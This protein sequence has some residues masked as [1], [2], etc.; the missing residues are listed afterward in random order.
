MK[1]HNNECKNVGDLRHRDGDPDLVGGDEVKEVVKKKL[2]PDM[3][4]KE[5]L[6]RVETLRRVISK[7]SILFSDEDRILITDALAVHASLIRVLG[8]TDE[9]KRT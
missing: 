2:T 1:G 7:Y 8:V 6:E 4:G 9:E 5:R 3:F